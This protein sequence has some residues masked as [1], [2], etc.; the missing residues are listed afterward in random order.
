M[1]G[2][3]P[4]ASRRVDRALER[5][6]GH[7]LRTPGGPGRLGRLQAGGQVVEGLP[8]AGRALARHGD[9]EP[10]AVDLPGDVRGIVGID[11]RPDPGRLRGGAEA[12]GDPDRQALSF[13]PLGFG[14]RFSPL[15]GAAPGPRES[16]PVWIGA[17]VL[18]RATSAAAFCCR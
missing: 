4:G 9:F 16:A 13:G 7:G 3:R 14:D 18:R 8:E 6:A 15:E 12:L 17:V 11:R 2:D 5:L 1:G 10:L